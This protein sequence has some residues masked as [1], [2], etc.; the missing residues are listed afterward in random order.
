M[1][2][3]IEL[4][5]CQRAFV[6]GF[7]NGS[8]IKEEDFQLIELVQMDQHVA[9]AEGEQGAQRRGGKFLGQRHPETE[10]FLGSKKE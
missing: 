6:E 2:R 3:E 10:R 5:T 7:D 4:N 1:L 9:Q 8:I